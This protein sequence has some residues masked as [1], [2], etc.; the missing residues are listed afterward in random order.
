MSPLN[1]TLLLAGLISATLTAQE[2]RMG[3]GLNLILPTGGFRSTSYGPTAEL[4]RGQEEGYDVGVGAQF[5]MSFPLDTRTAV[6][7]NLSGHS[8]RGTNTAPGE[9]T[10]TLEHN[11]FSLGAEMQFFSGSAYRHR[12]A[13][14]LAGVCADFESFSRGY[15]DWDM[16]FGTPDSTTRKSRTA[17]TFGVGRTFG[18]DSGMRFTLEGVYH[19]TL[20]GNDPARMEPPSTDFLKISFGWIF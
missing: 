6:R 10:L 5:T 11:L 13:Y 18:Y 2:P 15:G 4:P 12:G 8:V 1:R 19:K 9:A 16:Q 7:L 17:A 20:S 14:L 3:L